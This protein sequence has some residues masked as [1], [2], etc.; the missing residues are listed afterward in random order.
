MSANASTSGR[1]NKA[2]YLPRWLLLTATFCLISA[3]CYT[4]KTVL[5]Q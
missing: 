2:P 3:V 1:T 4:A 5:A